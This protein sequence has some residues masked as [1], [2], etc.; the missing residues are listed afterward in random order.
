M[1]EDETKAKAADAIRT[2]F[3]LD[4]AKNKRDGRNF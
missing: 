3:R 1:A 2:A 4:R